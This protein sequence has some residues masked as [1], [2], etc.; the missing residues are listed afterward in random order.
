MREVFSFSIWI[1]IISL[2]QRCIFNIAPSVLGVVSDSGEIAIFAPANTLESFF[3]M[4]ASAVNGL[5]LPMI[6]RYIAENDKSKIYQLMVKVGRYQ[7]VFLSLVFVSFISVGEEFMIAWM[8]K[9]FINTYPCVLFLFFPDIF[10]ATQQIANTVAIAKNKVKQQVLGYIGMAIICCILSFILCG[11]MGAL[12]SAIA[13]SLSYAF[14]FF[15]LSIRYKIDLNIDMIG[16]FKMCYFDLGGVVC[17]AAFFSYI[18]CKYIIID[19][20]WL[21]VIIK[22]LVTTIIYG[23]IVSFKLNDDEKKFINKHLMKLK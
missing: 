21:S 1:T 2:A 10:L 13:I 22:L 14:L 7:F 11:N 4:L 12:G 15:Y 9:D 18:A 17:C 16:F 23:V 20:I 19:S 6:S 3:F 8:G 5:F